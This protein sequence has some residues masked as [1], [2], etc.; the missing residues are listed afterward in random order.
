MLFILCVNTALVSWLRLYPFRN[1]SSLLNQILSPRSHL[2]CG[3]DPTSDWDPTSVEIWHQ[4]KSD[5]SWD[6]ISPKN[7]LT[8]GWDF[9]P[10]I[11]SLPSLSPANMWLLPFVR[12]KLCIGTIN[13]IEVTCFKLKI[14]IV[15]EKWMKVYLLNKKQ[16]FIC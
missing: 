15:I 9:I 14:E 7:H 13:G 12:A 4:L 8:S 2:T 11:I 16:K 10:M 3:W 6:P 5:I 1:I